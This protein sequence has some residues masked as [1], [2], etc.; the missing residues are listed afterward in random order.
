MKEVVTKV[1]VDKGAGAGEF[2]L[3]GLKVA[4]GTGVKDVTREPEVE[5]RYGEEGGE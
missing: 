5:Y 2:T 3:E 1:E 4:V